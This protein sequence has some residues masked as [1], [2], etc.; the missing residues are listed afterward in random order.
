[1]TKAAPH[2][3]IPEALCSPALREALPRIFE[4]AA[5]T[6][7]RAGWAEGKDYV[8]GEAE[9][10]EVINDAIETCLRGGRTWKEE[11]S[12]E[13]FLCSVIWSEVSHRRRS[14]ARRYVVGLDDIAEPMAPSSRR[15][16][17]FAACR[18]LARI[19]HAIGGDPQVEELFAI[20]ESGAE[21]PAARAVALGWPPERVKAV[22]ARMKRRL[23][24]AGLEKD[25][26]DDG[27]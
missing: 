23:A 21:K 19:K 20:I 26:D 5:R 18:L 8:P 11:M 24:A 7:R 3:P 12:L 2:P 22:D 9:A 27:P 6:L 14:T 13:A 16:D 1:M 4:Y 15:D 10:T 25:D 17:R